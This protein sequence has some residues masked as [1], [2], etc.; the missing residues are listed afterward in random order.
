MNAISNFSV[1]TTVGR[2]GR[3]I[4]CIAVV[5]W[6]TVACSRCV[7]GESRTPKKHVPIAA[8]TLEWRFAERDMICPSNSVVR[9]LSAGKCKLQGEHGMTIW[10]IPGETIYTGVE[11]RFVEV[12][13]KVE[14]TTISLQSASAAMDKAKPK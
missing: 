5:V 13:G 1:E 12:P 8:M 6:G 3:T 9:N 2:A 14:M 10:I 7:A 11:F 4:L